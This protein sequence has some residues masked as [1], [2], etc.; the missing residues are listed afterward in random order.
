MQRPSQAERP[1]VV[2]DAAVASVVA[3]AVVDDQQVSVKPWRLQLLS[4]QFSVRPRW[5]QR[6]SQLLPQ[7]AA[8]N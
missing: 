1:S 6:L 7:G 4:Q 2:W 5:P 8:R 3:P